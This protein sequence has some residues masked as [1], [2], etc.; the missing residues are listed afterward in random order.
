ML[1]KTTHGTKKKVGHSLKVNL[2][3]NILFSAFLCIQQIINNWKL[4]GSHKAYL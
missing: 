2:N 4:S 1:M 3:I